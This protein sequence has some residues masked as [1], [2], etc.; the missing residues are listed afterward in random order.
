MIVVLVGVKIVEIYH[1]IRLDV[2]FR[3]FSVVVRLLVFN[4]SLAR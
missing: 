1:Q 3:G 2:D 4:A